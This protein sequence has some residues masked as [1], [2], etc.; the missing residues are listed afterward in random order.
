MTDIIENLVN[1][2][3]KLVKENDKLK[4]QLDWWRNSEIN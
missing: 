2:I 3:D 4:A 1:R